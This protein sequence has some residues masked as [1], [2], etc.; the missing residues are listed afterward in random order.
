MLRSDPIDFARAHPL[1][2][3][4]YAAAFAFIPFYLRATVSSR[5]YNLWLFLGILVVHFAFLFSYFGSLF[6]P[7]GDMV[8]TIKP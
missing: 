4:V 3:I 8:T 7:V 1:L 5:Q 2:L 6:L